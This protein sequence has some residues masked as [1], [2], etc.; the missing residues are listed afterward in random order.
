VALDKAGAA[1]GAGAVAAASGLGDGGNTGL[2]PDVLAL[3]AGSST[4]PLFSST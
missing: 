3:A 1:A 2:D 4:R